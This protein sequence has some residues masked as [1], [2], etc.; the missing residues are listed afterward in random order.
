MRF[1]RRVPKLDTP[2]ALDGTQH[3]RVDAVRLTFFFP[4]ELRA[5]WRCPGGCGRWL[6]QVVPRSRWGEAV[7][8]VG[9]VERFQPA[10]DDLYS[11]R[12]RW[13]EWL[14]STDDVVAGFMEAQ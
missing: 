9:Q 3:V 8:A 5:M 6:W 7:R 4:D 12:A 11:A 2:C 14:W 10:R 13:L 1:R